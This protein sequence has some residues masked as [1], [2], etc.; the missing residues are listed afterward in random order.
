M[1][2]KIILGVIILVVIVGIYGSFKPLPPGLALEGKTYTAPGDSVHF[3]KDLT[4]TD[5][6]GVRH[7]EQEIFDEVF[8]LIREAEHYILL[9]MFL[10]NDF[11]GTATTSHR[12][13]S[14]ELTDTLIESKKQ[15]PEIIIQVITDPINSMYGGYHPEHFQ[16]LET[17]G[18]S[19]ITTNLVPL[20]DSNPTYSAWWRTFFM[21]LPDQGTG[22]FLPNIMDANKPNINMVS[23]LN[24]FNLK[25]NHRKV[26]M[27]DYSELGKTGF[28]VL[29]TSANPHDGSG[30][31]SN[32]AIRIDDHLWR[33]V[34][35]SERAVVSASGVEFIEPS[36]QFIETIEDHT[37]DITIQLLTEGAIKDKIIKLLNELEARD[38]FDMTMFYLSDREIIQALKEADQRGVMIRILLDPNKD[39]FSREKSGV[40]NRQVANELMAHTSGNTKIR[41]CHTHGEQC[42]SKLLIFQ[43]DGH[44][45]L[46]QG[47]ANL[48]RR[49]LDNLNL[50]TNVYVSGSQ[51]VRVI[52]DA[53]S[54]F[55]INWNNTENKIFST[56]YD[57]YADTS[58]GKTIWYRMG[59]F[60]GMSQ[61]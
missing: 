5:P 49:N 28:S 1:I 16:D 59:E 19:V 25:A 14:R 56:N 8:R 60:T 33:E 20:R 57:N 39:A 36:Q 22:N 47:S 24:S 61:Y 4:Y 7:S 9:D 43:K 45:S 41:W 58:T 37:G 26:L 31:H 10:F 35:E 12:A 34:L 3:F 2:K 15:N 13:L 21:W 32:T 46:V 54:F 53:L 38:T 23:Y 27:A 42:H 6:E 52:S 17:A 18:I 44:C 55:D 50:E 40:P 48:T 29:V 51:T 30:A 11:L